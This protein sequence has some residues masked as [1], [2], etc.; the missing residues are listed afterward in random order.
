MI[1]SRLHLL[2]AAALAASSLAAGRAQAQVESYPG[3]APGDYLRLGA[4]YVTPVDPKGGI[5]EWKPGVSASAFWENWEAS[6][7]GTSRVGFGVGASYAMLPLD[8]QHFLRDFSPSGGGTAASATANRAGILQ[9]TTG[10]RVRI[11]A[12]LVMPTINLGFGFINW[13][14]SKID[15]TTTSGQTGSVQQQHRSGAEFSIGAGLDRTLYDRFAIFGEAMYTYGF[16]SYGQ[17]AAP[18]G[19]C[20]ANTCDLLTNTTIAVLRGGLRTRLGR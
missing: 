9:I 18:S 20:R 11:P 13:A 2:V 6:S 4:G 1:E 14:P 3:L 8:E 15:Y 17:F 10:L 16:T 7:L 5:T 12:P 19:T